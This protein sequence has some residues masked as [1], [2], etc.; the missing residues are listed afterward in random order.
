M[1][2]AYSVPVVWLAII[3]GGIAGCVATAFVANALKG[4][5]VKAVA[6]NWAKHV[7]SIIFMIPVPFLIGLPAGWIIAFLWLVLAPTIASK[8]HFGP[9]DLPFMTLCTF[10]AGFAVVGLLVYALVAAAF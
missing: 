2:T 5:P 4:V 10:H 9:K 1:L 7:W 8:A 3:L 6:G